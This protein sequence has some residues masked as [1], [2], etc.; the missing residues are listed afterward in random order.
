MA[1]ALG[2]SCALHGAI[3]HYDWD[4]LHVLMFW[5]IAWWQVNQTVSALPCCY[6]DL[7][8]ESGLVHLA[9]FDH[10]CIVK[11]GTFEP[12]AWTVWQLPYTLLFNAL[13]NTIFHTMLMVSCFV[14]KDVSHSFPVILDILRKFRLLSGFMTKRLN[15][16]IPVH[17]SVCYGL[18][19]DNLGVMENHGIAMVT[20]SNVEQFNKCKKIF[21]SL[22][23][24][25]QS[26]AR[27]EIHWP[28][29][30]LSLQ[31]T[32]EMTK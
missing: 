1:E 20:S 14:W 19:M 9:R 18:G 21:G 5:C 22:A 32:L 23:F 30:T 10:L 24:L 11:S 25:P 12:L 31:D 17:I 13:Y 27:W 15:S 8:H 4:V 6:W 16:V 26:F 7:S 29:E 3:V 28:Y 2:S